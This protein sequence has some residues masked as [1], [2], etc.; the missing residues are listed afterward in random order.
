MEPALLPLLPF[1]LA[2]MSALCKAAVSPFSQTD[3]DYDY[4]YEEDGHGSGRLEYTGTKR[5]SEYDGTK[6]FLSPTSDCHYNVSGALKKSFGCEAFSDDVVRFKVSLLPLWPT[7]FAEL[8]ERQFIDKTHLPELNALMDSL[9]A[10]LSKSD[11][12]SLEGEI[13]RTLRR[14][15]DCLNSDT[16]IFVAGFADIYGPVEALLRA[17]AL[18]AT[19]PV[20]SLEGAMEAVRE[21]TSKQTQALRD[22]LK[23]LAILRLN[24]TLQATRSQL[25]SF[26]RRIE[27]GLQ[28]VDRHG[29]G[30]YR[31]VKR[32]LIEEAALLVTDAY[33]LLSEALSHQDPQL[34][35]ATVLAG[36]FEVFELPK[37]G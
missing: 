7:F 34:L 21:E 23:D 16:N 9:A 32:M 27:E 30:M 25:S 31:I 28:H 12:V 10:Q 6:L 24:G 33:Y 29:A 17:H 36:L 22:A 35:K 5:K 3:V 11:E 18:A 19:Y 14:L 1:V 4:E 2:V 8:S 37:Y 15:A 20:F 26:K 13:S